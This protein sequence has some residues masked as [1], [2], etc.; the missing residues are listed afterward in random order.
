MI[1]LNMHRDD[2]TS[3][4]MCD[5]IIGTPRSWIPTAGY[6]G[7]D[8]LQFHCVWTRTPAALRVSGVA[9]V[10][11]D[12]RLADTVRGAPTVAAARHAQPVRHRCTHIVV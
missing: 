8:D 1:M 11:K 9:A 6:G 10:A 12:A 2:S 7:P 3:N 4:L 5:E